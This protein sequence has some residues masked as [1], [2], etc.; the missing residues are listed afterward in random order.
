MVQACAVQRDDQQCL[1]Q[2]T[3][4]CSLCVNFFHDVIELVFCSP[5]CQESPGTLVVSVMLSSGSHL[6][7]WPAASCKSCCK[8]HLVF[9]SLREAEAVEAPPPVAS[10]VASMW[11]REA[12]LL[13][14]I[15]NA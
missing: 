6:A 10:T 3:E 14:H 15:T 9:E 7:G 5:A 4:S 13:T 2:V 8:P 11:S 1:W 12:L